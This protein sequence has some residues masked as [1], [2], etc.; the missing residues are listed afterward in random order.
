MRD[1]FAECESGSLRTASNVHLKEARAPH[2]VSA[3]L[4]R[5]DV[6]SIEN[7]A[8]S[9]VLFDRTASSFNSVSVAF[10]YIGLCVLFW[11]RLCF[12]RVPKG[13]QQV[14]VE[15]TVANILR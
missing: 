10:T 6:A 2:V 13:V 7:A 11:I 8:E 14:N 3:N 1:P 9:E 4:N 15:T 12:D 5:S